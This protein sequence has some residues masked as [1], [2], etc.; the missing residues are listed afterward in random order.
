MK[1]EL[2]DSKDQGSS[3][4]DGEEQVYCFSAMVI[5]Y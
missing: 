3:S 1:G 4:I 2:W 5:Y